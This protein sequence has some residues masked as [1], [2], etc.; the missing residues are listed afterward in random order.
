LTN[1]AAVDADTRPCDD[2]DDDDVL[3]LVLVFVLAL[4]DGRVGNASS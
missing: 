3:V 4:E 2:N 1:D